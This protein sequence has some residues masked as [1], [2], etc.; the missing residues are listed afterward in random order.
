MISDH[1]DTFSSFGGI[2]SNSTDPTSTNIDNSK[3]GTV[4]TIVSYLNNDLECYSVPHIITITTLLLAIVVTFGVHI[5]TKRI[6]VILSSKS[7]KALESGFFIPGVEGLILGISFF[8][9]FMVDWVFG[10]SGY[11]AYCY[12]MVIVLT[13][14]YISAAFYRPLI[15]KR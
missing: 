3:F 1:E 11:L 10:Y 15:Q 5:V 13:T 14:L 4:F 9:Y 6:S 8:N 2:N 7:K 12:A